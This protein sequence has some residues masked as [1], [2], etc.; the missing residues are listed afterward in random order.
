MKIARQYFDA[1]EATSESLR[2]L[3]ARRIRREGRHPSLCVLCLSD[4]DGKV[5]HA[6]TN[7]IPLHAAAAFSERM[8]GHVWC[9]SSNPT[10]TSTVYTAAC[11]SSSTA[12]LQSIPSKY[13]RASTE[14]HTSLPCNTKYDT[15]R[16]SGT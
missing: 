2:G 10:G 15:K 6:R 11:A 7:E 12:R 13:H 4:F 14:L 1:S 8:R 16:R 5:R 3:S 9:L